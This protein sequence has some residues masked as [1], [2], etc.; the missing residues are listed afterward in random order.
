MNTSDNQEQLLQS[1]WQKAKLLTPSINPAISVHRQNHRSE[2]WYVLKR[3]GSNRLFRISKENWHILGL[4][5]GQR[6]LEN[7]FGIVSQTHPE[8][9]ETALL[10]I[11]DQ[12]FKGGL[13][14]LDDAGRLVAPSNAHPDSTL[15][16]KLKNP[17]FIRIPL[18]DP[19]RFLSKYQRHVSPFFTLPMMI[20][21]IITLLVAVFN[22]AAHWDAIT[23]NVIDRVFTPQSLI[24][25][26]CIYPV[27]KLIHELGHAFAVKV[28]GGE[29]HDIGIV[30]MYGIPLPYVEASDALTFQN[31]RA[32]LLV[33][34]IGIMVEL[35]LAS[36][37]L[38]VWL[39]VS[40]GL[41]SQ[42][43][44]NTMIICSIS[45]IFFN[46]NPLMRFDG[47]YFLSDVLDIPNLATRSTLF[48]RYLFK[49]YV[50]S[51]PLSFSSSSNEKRWLIAYAPLALLYRYIVLTAITIA[52]AQLYLPLGIA[53]G[54]WFFSTQVVKPAL[55]LV[56]YLLSEELSH[57]RTRAIQVAVISVATIVL[58]VGVI[59]F[60]VKRTLPA[61][62]WF[63]ESS[64]VRAGA[65][66]V[67][68]SMIAE[69]GKQVS[70]GD[71]LFKLEDPYLTLK[72]DLVQYRLEEIEIKLN[73][74]MATDPVEAQ[75]LREEFT[76]T[77]SELQTLQQELSQLEVVSAASGQFY[78]PP[79]TEA[80]GSFV[81]KGTTLA[82]ILDRD[83]IVLRG[84][85]SQD[86]VDV[87]RSRSQSINV[88][89][90]NWPNRTYT[91]TI[92]RFLPTASSELPSAVLGTAY[93]GEASVDPTDPKGNLALEEWFQ[94]EVTVSASELSS[95]AMLWV[96]SRA[97]VQF[98]TDKETLITQF[99][100]RI[101]QLLMEKLHI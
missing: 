87:I 47:Y 15:L 48:W 51:L 25:I 27:T 9:S 81:E 5:N 11:I 30:L 71:I 10:S 12:L 16:E 64:E 44:Y 67:V 45:T 78:L 22:A 34:G 63:P 37:A 36:C 26:W 7:L 2:Q 60:P 14:Q 39:N 1:P 94:F 50:L 100:L 92:T 18:W 70:K 32:R 58:I 101:S 80:S 35:F 90:A 38:Y 53:I 55:N 46:G 29:V 79:E 96:G 59:P 21:W 23:H 84:L 95:D 54:I 98:N 33:D 56:L 42:L 82:Y 77:Q 20:I 3:K 13:I 76:F 52:A 57:K 89:L 66:G 97:W 43:A 17:F 93:G 68:K 99:Y 41:I 72:R 31:K 4:C 28:N 73:A 24:L 6:N 74:A 69:E 61:V 75:L 19:D 62:V 65:E 85:I 83:T 91:A 49:R 8:L 40:S 88:K 86:D